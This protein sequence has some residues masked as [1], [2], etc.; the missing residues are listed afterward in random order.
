MTDQLFPVVRL[1][2]VGV[3]FCAGPCSQRF[4][5]GVCFGAEHPLYQLVAAH[6]QTEVQSGSVFGEQ[7]KLDKGH[8]NS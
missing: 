4:Y 6:F 2:A 8:I 5:I 3:D 1:W 7:V